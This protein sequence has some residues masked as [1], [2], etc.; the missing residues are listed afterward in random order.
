MCIWFH[1]FFPP[2]VFDLVCFETV[3][4]FLWYI[5]S[6]ICLLYKPKEVITRAPSRWEQKQRTKTFLLLFP[7][8]KLLRILYCICID[9]AHLIQSLTSPINLTCP[10][11]RVQMFPFFCLYTSKQGRCAVTNASRTRAEAWVWTD[12]NWCYS[13]RN[14]C[15]FF[16]SCNYAPHVNSSRDLHEVIVGATSTDAFLLHFN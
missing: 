11:E 15:I 16:N 5:P 13:R 8:S 1:F 12:L 10:R 4:V 2:T 6:R 9:V 14:Q 3:C 7:S